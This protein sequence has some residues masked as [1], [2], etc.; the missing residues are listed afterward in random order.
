MG[1]IVLSR[2]QRW[3]PQSAPVFAPRIKDYA[4]SNLI[5]PS[6]GLIDLQQNKTLTRGSGAS[7]VSGIAGVARRY[8]NS[9]NF[10]KGTGLNT[11]TASPW[12]EYTVMALLRTTETNSGDFFWSFGGNGGT[13]YLG[14]RA[15]GSSTS[16]QPSYGSGANASYTG[17]PPWAD[18]N[19]H[20]ITMVR[21]GSVGQCYVD[22]TLAGTT[23]GLGAL[24]TVYTYIGLGGLNR[25][26]AELP[27]ACDIALLCGFQR[28][29]PAVLIAELATNPWA[30][31]STRSDRVFSFSGGAANDALAGAAA[32]TVTASGT[33]TQSVP[34]AGA[35][36][37]VASAAGALSLS[38]PLAGAAAATA[39]AQGGLSLSIPLS[40]AAIATALA[41][42]GLSQ[43]TPLAGDAAAQAASGAD[44]SLAITLSG[45][46]I[47]QAASSAGL[48]VGTSGLSGDAQAVASASGSLSLTVPLAS[49]AL[50]VTNASGALTQLV[51]LAGSAASASLATGGLDISVQLSGA[52]LARALSTASLDVSGGASADL[53]GDAAATVSASATLTLYVSLAGAAIAHAIASGAL[54]GTGLLSPLGDPER[55][56]R[57]PAE[58]RV[59]RVRAEPRIFRVND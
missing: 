10:D 25:N 50:A 21:S 45:S 27:T 46:A 15:N 33:L 12:G 9:A 48:T 13:N 18:G 19:W 3:Q 57:I 52:A 44:L 39:N 29:M 1:Q 38:L 20:L 5:L 31:F 14:L 4:P 49:A 40:G 55:I 58:P 41:A 11:V 56:F 24:A 32:A 34:I 7:T 37:V 2:H 51:P 47:A 43:S 36:A 6:I 59:F 23:T 28:A 53:A 54:A 35:A 42:A 16:I 8:N 22:G 26:S 17:T 30:L